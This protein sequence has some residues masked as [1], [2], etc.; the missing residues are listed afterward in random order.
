MN[1]DKPTWLEKVWMEVQD[2]I[3]YETAHPQDTHCACAADQPELGCGWPHCRPPM[4]K[5]RS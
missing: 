1:H 4:N 5:E 2:E 3:D